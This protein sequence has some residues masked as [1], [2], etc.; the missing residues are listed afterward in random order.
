MFENKRYLTCGVDSTIPIELQLFLWECVER[1]AALKKYI[2]AKENM[3]VKMFETNADYVFIITEASGESDHCVYRS[4]DSAID[5]IRTNDENTRRI[6]VKTKLDRSYS[7]N[8]IELY[9]NEEAVPY[10]SFLYMS[11][12]HADQA[13]LPVDHLYKHPRRRSNVSSNPCLCVFLFLSA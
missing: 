4:L 11:G 3:L 7:Y 1:K 12:S 10:L 8:Q 2:Y 13:N 9:L 6:I 5:T